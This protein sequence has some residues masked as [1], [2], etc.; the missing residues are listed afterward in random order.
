M[1]AREQFGLERL[2]GNSLLVT[3]D[4]SQNSVSSI[5][6]MPSKPKSI[7]VT[8]HPSQVASSETICINHDEQEENNLSGSDDDRWSFKSES[9]VAGQ[10]KTV[11]G[12][13]TLP[14]QQMVV[15]V[16]SSSNPESSKQSVS[17]SSIRHDGVEHTSTTSTST[18]AHEV[19]LPSAHL[20]DSATAATTSG[21]LGDMA[22]AKL[23]SPSSD[24]LCHAASINLSG[25]P[26][27][28]DAVVDPLDSS[29]SELIEVVCATVNSKWPILARYFSLPEECVADIKEQD[30]GAEG[31]CRAVLTHLSKKGLTWKALYDVLLKKVS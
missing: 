26:P 7:S 31:K 1:E 15:P 10:R 8:D 25:S 5:A 16:H 24:W 13:S 19:K 27:G 12:L 9:T 11:G 6:R 30:A 28:P 29:S 4:E 18:S 14:S 21:H 3:D 17:E 2:S 20:P 23:P 22:V